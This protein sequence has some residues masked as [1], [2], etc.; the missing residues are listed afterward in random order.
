MCGGGREH[1]CQITLSIKYSI[2]K[3]EE[4]KNEKIIR[5]NGFHLLL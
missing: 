4:T 3:R 2:A 1:L 5:L